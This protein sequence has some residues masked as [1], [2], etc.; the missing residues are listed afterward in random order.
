MGFSPQVVA[1][2]NHAGS[3]YP[4]ASGGGFSEYFPRPRYQE[5]IVKNYLGSFVKDQ[6]KGLYNPAGRAYPDVSAIGMNLTTI[7]D[8]KLKPT[9]GTS[10]STPVVASIF[11]LVND[12]LITAGRPP[13][14]FLNPWLYAG[15][16]KAFNDVQSG[17]AVGCDMDGFEASTGW[18][19]VTGFGSPV[20]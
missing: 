15:G 1:Y 6:F 16:Y 17:S 2:S 4:Y 20:S 8:G 9:G 5:K 11:A 3:P 13:L 10:A 19:A 18:D 7:W 12:A 14:G